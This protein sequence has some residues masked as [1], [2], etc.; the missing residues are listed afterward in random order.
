MQ[1]LIFIKL[2]T[3][4]SIPICLCLPPHPSPTTPHHSTKHTVAMMEAET[5]IS[6]TI[7]NPLQIDKIN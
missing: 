2:H 3:I 1:D 7:R 4:L 6:H 5:D